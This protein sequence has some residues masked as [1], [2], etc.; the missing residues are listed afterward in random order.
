MVSY[1]EGV[2]K[3]EGPLVNIPLVLGQ[4]YEVEFQVRGPEYRVIFDGRE[5]FR[6]VAQNRS[7]WVGLGS[8]SCVTRYKDI[9]IT[10]PKGEDLW[11][12]LPDD[13]PAQ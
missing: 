4:W 10:N 6:Q 3:R 7:G 9:S 12:G 11:K 2:W 13:L 8:G 5:V 1:R